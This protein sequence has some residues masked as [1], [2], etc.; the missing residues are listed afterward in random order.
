MIDRKTLE[1]ELN[2]S[3][4]VRTSKDNNKNR[5]RIRDYISKHYPD[6]VVN[7]DNDKKTGRVSVYSV[8]TKD[9]AE[10]RYQAQKEI[11]AM[12]ARE[13]RARRIERA[14]SMSLK[15]GDMI[16]D[17]EILNSIELDI[18]TT[19]YPAPEAISTKCFVNDNV[20]QYRIRQGRIEYNIGVEKYWVSICMIE[21]V[22][23]DHDEVDTS[24]IVT[25]DAWVD[26]IR[27]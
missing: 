5:L 13:S 9:E 11:D 24:E 17:K 3:N 25:F 18:G 10:K 21:K 14:E 2:N 7:F 4:L 19:G 12:E 1:L 20:F 15:I 22:Y 23:Y 16:T 26:D 8:M 27:D 6:I